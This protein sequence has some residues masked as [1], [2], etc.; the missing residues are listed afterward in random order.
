MWIWDSLLAAA[1]GM[2]VGFVVSR[3]PVRKLSQ[4]S[5]VESLGGRWRE[6]VGEI[7]GVF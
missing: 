3:C 4:A 6:S 2:V 5:V 1:N 7:N